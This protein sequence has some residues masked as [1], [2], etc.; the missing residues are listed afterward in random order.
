MATRNTLHVEVVTAERE[1]YRGEADIVDAPGADGQ[2]GIL[3]RHEALLTLLS[4]GPLV[5]KLRD[6]EEIL[7]VS[8]GFLE[9]SN[10]HITVLADTAEHADEIDEARAEAARR[11]AQDRLADVRSNTERAELQAQLARAIN[12][13]RVAEIVRRSSD[14]RRIIMPHSED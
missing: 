9:V 8:G 10:D 12:R 4:S 5:I 1:L 6:A 11:T 14:R 7:F 2:I 3:P 13:I